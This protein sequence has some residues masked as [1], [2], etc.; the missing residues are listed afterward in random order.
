[1][2]KTY[3]E[4][5]RMNSA[6]VLSMIEVDYTQDDFVDGHIVHPT[7]HKLVFVEFPKRKGNIKGNTLSDHYNYNAKP[8]VFI[9]GFRYLQ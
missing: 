8:R 1:M 4:L 5:I 3:N 6:E 7:N 9:D 2:I